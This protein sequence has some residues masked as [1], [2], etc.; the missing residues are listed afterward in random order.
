M[1]AQQQKTNLKEYDRKFEEIKDITSKTKQK[2]VPELCEILRKADP[3]L[4]GKEIG[5]K[6]KEDCEE[7]VGW[8][9]D[10]VQAYLPSFAVNP[11]ASEARKKVIYETQNK[12]KLNKI[13]KNFENLA[14]VDLPEPPQPKEPKETFTPLTDEEIDN[15]GI[16]MY[17]FG[18]TGQK[19]IMSLQSDM[20]TSGDRLFKTLA[21]NKPL[22]TTGRNDIDADVKDTREWRLG[23]FLEMTKSERSVVSNIANSLIAVL[24]D[25]IDQIEKADK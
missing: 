8:N 9:W 17:P 10:T 21:N 18:E 5:N 14:Q 24:N 19:S 3:T 23:L 13:S 22:N 20:F 1:M 25:T 16:K 2:Y 12:D 15:T 11:K 6:V 7:R 4:E